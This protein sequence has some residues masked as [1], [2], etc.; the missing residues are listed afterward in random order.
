MKINR[1]IS[2]IVVF[3]SLYNC[4]TYETFYKK[5]QAVSS[6]VNYKTTQR[7][8]LGSM[9]Y[10]G[11]LK[12]MPK[13]TNLRALNL[14]SRPAEEIDT[15]L[16]LVSNPEL[17]QVLILDST[18]LKQLPKNILR[19]KNL[20]QLALN[21]NPDLDFESA[22][23]TLKKLPLE[24]LNLQY[25]NLTV[26]P[27]S[28]KKLKSLIDFNLSHNTI[29][30]NISFKR[31]KTLPKL[32][33]LWL[34]DNALEELPEALFELDKLKN[35]Y[36]EHNTLTTIPEGI[37]AMRDVWVIHAG[38]NQFKTLPEAFSKMHCLL[39]LHANNCPIET[40]PEGYLQKTSKV[41][42]LILDENNLPERAKRYWRKALQHFFVLSI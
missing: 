29:K 11:I 36:I 39:L 21:K 40:I 31:L 19:F 12:A 4:N 35:L 23:N 37:T 34:T 7:L 42:G 33:S 9:A 15:L 17:L 3:L 28:I 8:E 30:S 38:H 13:F 24:F 1:I 6:D 32:K 2:L 22:F 41:A 25:N 5:T 18:G 20:K 27:E 10:N 26:L 16:R 14:S